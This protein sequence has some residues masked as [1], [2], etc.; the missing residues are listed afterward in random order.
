M[1]VITGSARGRRLETLSG[2]DVRPTTEV[3]KEA[4]F[5]SIQFEIEGRN[6]LDLF[7]GSGQ[8]AIEAL[9]RGA[10]KAT[11][12]D[13]DSRAISIIRKNLESTKLSDRAVVL[14][15]D[16]VSFAASYR[17]SFDIVF[18]DPPYGTGVLQKVIPLIADKVNRGGVIICESP[19]TED[20]P[21]KAGEFSLF[22]EYKYGKTKI[23]VYRDT[24]L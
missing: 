13:G 23:T 2:E 12:V 20:L 14:Q 21:K 19:K 15:T 10:A 1:R 18:I 6:M 4:V 8:M 3:V 7:G 24:V 9:S 22:K 17:G 5:S 16:S 11:V